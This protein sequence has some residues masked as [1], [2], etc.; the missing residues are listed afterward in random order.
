M[1]DYNLGDVIVRSGF[2]TGGGAAGVCS[3]NVGAVFYDSYLGLRGRYLVVG[4]NYCSDGSAITAEGATITTY[5]SPRF[6]VSHL[7]VVTNSISP[8]NIIT[9]GSI[10]K[11]ENTMD[12][13]VGIDFSM[14]V[15]CNK[16]A[17]G[18]AINLNIRF[19][20]VLVPIA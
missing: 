8:S 16:I 11:F 9:V 2:A 17:V 15:C 14:L 3:F 20:V 12:P 18:S 5:L 19:H 13:A 1:I 7:D 6:T 4:L 10:L